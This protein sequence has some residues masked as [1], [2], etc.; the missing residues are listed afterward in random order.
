[1]KKVF[2]KKI[3]ELT[4]SD[5]NGSFTKGC[6]VYDLNGK[7]G[8]IL[9]IFYYSMHKNKYS[10]KFFMFSCLARLADNIII[11]CFVFTYPFP[12]P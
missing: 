11:T 3:T 5:V 4:V 10:H 7:I 12:H 6:E 8:Y 9:L 2:E 1:M